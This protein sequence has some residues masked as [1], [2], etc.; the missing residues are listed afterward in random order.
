MIVDIEAN[1]S[2]S[3]LTLP[4]ILKQVLPSNIDTQMP[5]TQLGSNRF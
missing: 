3:L 5:T 1:F 2:N 4:R